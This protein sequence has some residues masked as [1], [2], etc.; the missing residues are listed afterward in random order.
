[1]LLFQR[2]WWTTN[3]ESCGTNLNSFLQNTCWN[4][5]DLEYWDSYSSDIDETLS[6]FGVQEYLSMQY[7]SSLVIDSDD[8][9][10]IHS[11]DN[12][13]PNSIWSLQEF[14]FWKVCN[15]TNSSCDSTDWIWKYVWTSWF[16][17]SLC[18]SN[19]YSGSTTYKWNY[20]Y[21]HNG[22]LWYSS[23]S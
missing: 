23:N 1:M 20:W 7:N 10:I 4:S 11:S 18:N 22:Y 12:L 8:S 16:S 17:S 21:C 2:A 13:F 14:T 5:S 15:I 9:Y 3:I 19:N 6:H